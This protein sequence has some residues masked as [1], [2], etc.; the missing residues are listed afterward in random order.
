MGDCLGIHGV[1]DILFWLEDCHQS[2]RKLTKAGET[3]FNLLPLDEVELAEIG[4]LSLDTEER[5]SRVQASGLA[6]TYSN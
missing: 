1:V 6:D 2:C 5:L 3:C 4:C